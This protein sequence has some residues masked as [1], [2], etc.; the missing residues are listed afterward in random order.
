M[1][2]FDALEVD[3]W[4]C[5]RTQ[6][7]SELFCKL[8]G[9]PQGAEA[10]MVAEKLHRTGSF[11]RV[12]RAETFSQ[13]GRNFRARNCSRTRSKTSFTSATEYDASDR[14]ASSSSERKTLLKASSFVDQS[15]WSNVW[16]RN[17][18]AFCGNLCKYSSVDTLCESR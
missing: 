8:S 6:N 2:R 13:V 7:R 14:L 15:K 18:S 11:S 12:S 1:E 9:F 17:G 4:E 5:F 16:G 3:A 10:E